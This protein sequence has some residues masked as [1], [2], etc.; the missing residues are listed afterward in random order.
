VSE[1]QSVNFKLYKEVIKRLIARVHR[2]RPEF[3]ENGSW[4][5]LHDS[6]RRYLRALSPSLWRNEGSP[7]YPIYPTP[8]LYRRLTFFLSK[9]KIA[10]KGTRFEAVSS[11][12]QTV[13]RE[14]KA[15]RDE[16][17]S[18]AS[19]SLY[20]RCKRCAEAGGDYIE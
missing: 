9:L 6:A 13:T 2:F 15:M 14:L 1:K 17:F 20:E 8:L 18:R 7:C 10:M 3:Q 19:D 4:Y 16:A 11:I 5:L 12:Q